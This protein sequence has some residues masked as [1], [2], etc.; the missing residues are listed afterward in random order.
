MMVKDI[1]NVQY[2]INSSKICC[3]L[4]II[5]INGKEIYNQ[6]YCCVEKIVKMEN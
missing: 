2:T 1:I 5:D 4:L 6:K 3:G